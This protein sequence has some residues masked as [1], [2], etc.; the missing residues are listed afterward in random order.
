MSQPRYQ[1]VPSEEALYPQIRY[2]QPVQIPI[3]H[4]QPVQMQFPVQLQPVQMQPLPVQ[5]PMMQQP[6][7]QQQIYYAQPVPPQ[8]AV[9]P[10]GIPVSVPQPPVQTARAGPQ[11]WSHNLCNCTPGICFMATCCGPCRWAT[12]MS[13]AGIMGYGKALALL[14]IPAFLYGAISCF[15]AY[16]SM[17]MYMDMYWDEDWSWTSSTEP[18]VEPL[19]PTNEASSTW[20][21]YDWDYDWDYDWGGVSGMP[22]FHLVQFAI[23]V[24]VFSLV[25]YGRKRLRALYQIQGTGCSDCFVWYWC[26]T[27]ALAQ[28]A[29]HVDTATGHV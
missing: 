12:T 21:S 5:Q 25:V 2:A 4:Q 3:Q 15:Q 1:Q 10:T 27:C 16:Q 18:S 23:A 7:P 8:M 6:M 20:T 14:L 17:E 29:M 19:S 13:R 28:E 9:V 24:F 22:M 11:R 26:S